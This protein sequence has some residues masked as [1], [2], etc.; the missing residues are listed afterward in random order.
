LRV[1]FST[2]P[3][4]LQYRDPQDRWVPAEGRVT[5][6]KA[7]VTTIHLRR[8]PPRSIPPCSPAQTICFCPP[9]W[10]VH[11]IPC[12][13]GRAITPHS[14]IFSSADQ[15]VP[16]NHCGITHCGSPTPIFF[17]SHPVFK[18]CHCHL[19]FQRFCSGPLSF[20]F[21][22]RPFSFFRKF[23]HGQVFASVFGLFFF[24]F[25]AGARF[26]GFFL[27]YGF[28]LLNDFSFIGAGQV[29]VL[30]SDV[31][32]FSTRPLP[33]LSPFCPRRVFRASPA[34]VLPLKPSQLSLPN[35]AERVL[36]LSRSCSSPFF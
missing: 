24:P 25:F 35:P 12:C 30:L 7:P 19:P 15:R 31:P 27:S 14:P 32:P 13:L 9:V 22:H 10:F 26:S 29:H 18:S 23:F 5:H 2:G 33:A 20:S 28:C 34:F 21:S 3:Q 1:L 16:F 36:L 11:P 17:W 6:S 4:K 8:A